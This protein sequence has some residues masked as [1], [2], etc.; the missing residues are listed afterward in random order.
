MKRRPL[1][2]RIDCEKCGMPT[3]QKGYAGPEC[4]CGV[5]TSKPAPSHSAGPLKP[6]D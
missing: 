2:A 5:D 3:N 6:K 4:V 1:P